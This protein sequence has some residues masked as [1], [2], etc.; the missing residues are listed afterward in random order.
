[1]YDLEKRMF[2]LCDKEYAAFQCKLIPTISAGTVLGIR[3]PVLRNLAKEFRKESECEAFLE[4]LPHRYYDEN[5]FHS[6]LLCDVKDY[7]RAIE[8][9]DSFL[10]YIDNWAV[11]DT[12]S[13]KVFKKHR[14]KLIEKIMEWT[15]SDKVYTCRFGIKMLMAHFLDE[16]FK[17]EYLKIPEAVKSDEYYVKMMVAWYFATAL[18]KQWDATIPYIEE[19]KLDIWTHNK[20]IQKARESYRITA[21][22]KEYLKTLRR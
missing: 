13:P 7:E 15:K 3:V 2:E 22:Q 9:V 11:C 18:A 12:L 20:T 8:Y 1:M 16:D 4:S 17:P 21:D 6:I 14:S 5:M 19:N 10:P